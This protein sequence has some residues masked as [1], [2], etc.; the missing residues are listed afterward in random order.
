[1][2]NFDKNNN[3]FDF[4][5]QKSTKTFSQLLANNLYFQKDSNQYLFEYAKKFSQEMNRQRKK[6]RERENQRMRENQEKI[7]QLEN[8]AQYKKDYCE[9]EKRNNRRL[10]LI[11]RIK[12]I[13]EKRLLNKSTL[14]KLAEMKHNIFS[15]NVS[16]DFGKSNNDCSFSKS[17]NASIHKSSIP[18]QK[19]SANFNKYYSQTPIN[20]PMINQ[21]YIPPGTIVK[22]KFCISKSIDCSSEMPHFPKDEI[23]LLFDKNTRKYY[24]INNRPELSNISSSNKINGNCDN[25]K[26]SLTNIYGNSFQDHQCKMK[27][28][29][30]NHLLFDNLLKRQSLYNYNRI[31]L[32]TKANLRNNGKSFNISQKNKEHMTKIFP[33]HSN[34]NLHNSIDFSIEKLFSE[35]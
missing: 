12:E 22:N 18:I 23:P 13:E 35:Y 34:S 19:V 15:K 21:F 33:D 17:K 5:I 32:T 6:L 4:I 24:Q 27:G 11:S 16:Y 31:N 10:Q 3:S 29:P 1:M 26:S 20:N 30:Q 9:F 28:L 2:C 14:C 7:K 25:Y 8:E